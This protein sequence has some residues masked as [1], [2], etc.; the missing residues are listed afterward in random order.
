LLKTRVSFRS[1]ALLGF[2]SW[3]VNNQLHF[4][5][6]FSITLERESRKSSTYTRPLDPLLR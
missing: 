4:S 2:A 5:A 6:Y 1:F 3:I